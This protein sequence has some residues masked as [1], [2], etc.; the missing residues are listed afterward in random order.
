MF[1]VFQALAEMGIARVFSLKIAGQV[2]ACRLGFQCGD[3]LYLY[4]S[5]F[6]PAW[7]KYSVMT[8]TVAEAVKYAIAAGLKTVNLSPGL[9]VSKTRWGPTELIYREARQIASHP[10]AAVAAHSFAAVQQARSYL[11]ISKLSGGLLQRS[12]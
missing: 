6:D 1:D 3:S 7:G 8:T 4:Y 9:D 12:W 5:G 10:R 2:V 11:W